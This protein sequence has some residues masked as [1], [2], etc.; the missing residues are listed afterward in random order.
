MR[1]GF[2]G[3]RK[4]MT[5]EQRQTVRPLLADLKPEEAHHGDAIGA[6]A[7]FHAPAKETGVALLVI[8]PP[9]ADAERAFCQGNTIRPARHHLARNRRSVD[10][11]ELLIATPRGFKEELRCGT[12]AT[13]RYG[14]KLGRPVRIVWP[15]GS[16]KVYMTDSRRVMEMVAALHKLGYE[17]LRLTPL[18]SP[19]GMQNPALECGERLN[20]IPGLRILYTD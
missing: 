7:E 9:K 11:T 8:H 6:D 1:I 13:I 19:T 20:L 10:E 18:I 15:D 2:T 5:E 14:R 12:W 17:R 3:T 16:V 4:G